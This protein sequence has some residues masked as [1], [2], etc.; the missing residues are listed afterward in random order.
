MEEDRK[1]IDEDIA[2]LDPKKLPAAVRQGIAPAMNANP[3]HPF[4]EKQ[5]AQEEDH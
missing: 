3:R 5:D 4:W 2:K 1:A